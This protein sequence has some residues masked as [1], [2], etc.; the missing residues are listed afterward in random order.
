MKPGCAGHPERAIYSQNDAGKMLG[1]NPIPD[2][3]DYLVNSAL[4]PV[5][6]PRRYPYVA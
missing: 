3:D 1:L 5:A 2:G 6:R 4:Q